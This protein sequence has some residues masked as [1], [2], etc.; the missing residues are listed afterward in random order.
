MKLQLTA[1]HGSVLFP[2]RDSEQEG[3]PNE[4][5][6]TTTNLKGVVDWEGR[7]GDLQSGQ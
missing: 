5:K 2:C 7:G 3:T 6:G 4:E 1:L